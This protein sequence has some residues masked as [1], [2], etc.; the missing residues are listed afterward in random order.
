MADSEFAELGD[1][2]A[3]FARPEVRAKGLADMKAAMSADARRA[4]EPPQMSTIPMPEFSGPAG[5]M[6]ARFHCPR[7]C[8]WFHDESTNIGPT[9]L[10]I[11][12]GPGGGDV[13]ELNSLNRETA[14]LGLR[15]RVEDAVAAHYARAH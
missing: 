7:L 4:A 1:I 3:Y 5:T 13:D 8:G 15:V 9:S 6:T 11:A 2:Q 12:V 14:G 10:V